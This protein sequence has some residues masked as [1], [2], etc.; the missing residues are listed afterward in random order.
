MSDCI[1]VVDDESPIRQIMAGFLSEAGYSVIQA[2]DGGTAMA[3]V[4]SHEPALVLLDVGMPG[5][6]GWDVLGWMRRRVAHAGIPVIMMS[7]RDDDASK[8]ISWNL[9]CAWFLAKPFSQESLTFIVRSVLAAH[10]AAA[11][12]EENTRVASTGS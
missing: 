8:A 1:L 5:L 9:G 6:T 11:H 10:I 2:E 3:A 7:G 4:A 12:T